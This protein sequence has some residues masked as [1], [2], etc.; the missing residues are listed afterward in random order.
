[1]NRRDFLGTLLGMVATIPLVKHLI[2]PKPVYLHKSYDLGFLIS[3]EVLNDD[4]YNLQGTMT[5]RISASE[6]RR[7]HKTI[8]FAPRYGR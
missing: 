7:I 5:G 8:M 2:K 3:E 1:M 6:M 4:L